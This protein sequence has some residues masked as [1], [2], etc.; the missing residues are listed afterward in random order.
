MLKKNQIVL[1][2][3]VIIR[4]LVGDDRALYTKSERV[5]TDIEND[6]VKATILESVF[7]ETV[8][9]LE[10][11]YK[12]ERGKIADLLSRILALKGVRNPNKQVYRQALEIYQ[13]QKVDIVDC[14]VCAYGLFN[15]VDIV[16][17]DKDIEACMKWARR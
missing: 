12:V 9:V 2:T 17:F 14:L 7:A 11:V 8:F 15:E 6:V 5:F 13:A 3:N 4:F 1:D 10:K 16:S